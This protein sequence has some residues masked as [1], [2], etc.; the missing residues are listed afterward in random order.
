MP[1]VV[2]R[3]AASAVTQGL[4]R[5]TLDP[6]ARALHALNRL[7]Y[8]PRPGDLAQI[9]AQGADLWLERFL[10][11]QFAP[12]SIELP[13]DLQARLAALETTHLS[14]AEL[15]ARFR[16]VVSAATAP[17]PGSPVSEDPAALA[18]REHIRP[19]Q[20][21][22]ARA[23]LCL[24]IESPAQ[25]REI[26]VDFWFNHFNVFSGKGQV[27]VLAG[28]YEREAIRPHVLGRFRELLGAT[29]KHPAMLF[30]LDNAL[31]VKPGFRPRAAAGPGARP[32][33]LN[34]NYARELMELHTL[35]VDGGYTQ[36][37]VTALA[38][39]LTGWTVDQRAARLGERGSLF[40]FDP[41][42]H[43]D[44]RK[45]WLGQVVPGHGQAEGEW[46]LDVLAAH[47]ATARHL[48]HKLARAF[49]AD[50]PPARLVHRLAERYTQT[51]GNLREVM[52]SLVSSEEF[53]SRD[54]A[55]AKFKTPYH[56]LV[57]SLRATDTPV[58]DNVEALL[59]HLAQAGMPL[60]R[61]PTPEGYKDLASAWLHAEAL[62]QRVQF[63]L[64]L[65]RR[66]ARQGQ[67]PEQ[68]ARELLQTLGPLISEATRRTVLA[69]PPRLQLA[70]LLG[71]PDFMKR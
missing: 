25:L 13:A 37:D 34:E 69:E 62:P 35:G 51:D 8:G 71:S 64:N 45:H 49:V 20:L 42:R 54:V 9:R 33:G 58:P 32:T 67:P 24:A 5:P 29:A 61:A 6:E 4:E 68:D 1:A 3:S 59:G 23:R 21:E 31:S 53:W 70:L 18:R 38:R 50:D 66:R 7:A 43:D 27:S 30:Y 39:I 48:A 65:A 12:G 15:L 46:A 26:L 17:T 14:Q 2:P 44:E 28:A 55:S 60:Y 63:G 57:S 19:V 16:R 40:L 52:L 36:A 22:A 11:A 41:A 10:A 56:Y 47:P